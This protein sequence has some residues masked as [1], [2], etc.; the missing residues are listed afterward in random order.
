[1]YNLPEQRNGSIVPF[2]LHHWARSLRVMVASSVNMMCSISPGS[3]DMV[4]VTRK[5]GVE[6][7]ETFGSC[8]QS[9][10]HVRLRSTVT[11]TQRDDGLQDAALRYS[12]KIMS[13]RDRYTLL[14]TFYAKLLRNDHRGL[15]SH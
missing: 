5:R 15:L 1:M 11:V 10:M 13:R 8:R 2:P 6:S 4:S 7:K 14:N 3:R 12:R 9:T